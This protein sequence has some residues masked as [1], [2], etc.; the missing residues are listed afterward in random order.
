M[1]HYHEG[2]TTYA[3]AYMHLW[4]QRMMHYIYIP[5]H[6]PLNFNLRHL[7]IKRMRKSLVF[8]SSRN[9]FTEQKLILQSS[10]QIINPKSKTAICVMAGEK[11]NV[12]LLQKFSV[13]YPAAPLISLLGLRTT[14][15]FGHS[16]QTLAS[17]LQLMFFRQHGFFLLIK[18]FNVS[19][20]HL[21][22]IPDFLLLWRYEANRLYFQ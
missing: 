2:N 1:S 12:F 15:D 4:I 9:R 10:M 21:D 5:W 16:S 6:S 8:F 11:G 7:R 19:F 17:K 18:G 14:T 22:L 20:Y 13:V 3:Y